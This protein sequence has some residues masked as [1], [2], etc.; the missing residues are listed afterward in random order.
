MEYTNDNKLT[1]QIN[2]SLNIC[3][4]FLMYTLKNVNKKVEL[5]VVTAVSFLTLCSFVSFLPWLLFLQLQVRYF[6]LIIHIP[7]TLFADREPVHIDFT[8]TKH[9]VRFQLDVDT[10]CSFCGDPNE[11]ALDI[12]NSWK[13]P[14]L[15]SKQWSF[16]RYSLLFPMIIGV[17]DATKSHCTL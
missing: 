11:T 10:G 1:G 2:N 14:Q 17:S 13:W 16:S 8:Q 5:K 7:H 9:L 15:L 6:C 12:F 3:T 4:Q